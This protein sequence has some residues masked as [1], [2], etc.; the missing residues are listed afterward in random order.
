MPLFVRMSVLYQDGFIHIY[1]DIDTHKW[2][3]MHI[4]ARLYLYTYKMHIYEEK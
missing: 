4:Y 3:Y 1:R 2:V